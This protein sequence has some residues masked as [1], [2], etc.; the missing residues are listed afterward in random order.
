[1]YPDVDLE[2]AKCYYELQSYNKAENVLLEALN[3]NTVLLEPNKF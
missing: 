2:I 3:S 1:M